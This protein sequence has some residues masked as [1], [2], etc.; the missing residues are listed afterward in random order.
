MNNNFGRKYPTLTEY[1]RQYENELS[2]ILRNA[3]EK[4]EYIYFPRRGS[5]IIRMRDNRRELVDLEPYY[6]SKHKLFFKFISDKNVFGYSKKPYYATSDTY[7]LWPKGNENDIDY[8][9]YLAYLNSKL[10]YFLFKAKNLFIKRSKTKLENN[11]P[12]PNKN[13]FN[14]PIELAM[15]SIIKLISKYLIAMSSSNSRSNPKPHLEYILNNEIYFGLLEEEIR[16]KIIEGIEKSDLKSLQ[17]I[18]DELFFRLFNIEEEKI[19]YLVER[20]Y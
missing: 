8:P 13:I 6:D 2:E 3:K 14:D 17:S 16:N 12:V 7:F 11:L 18:L 20:Y 5:F 15:I 1:I 4:Q 10:V 19:D 9:F